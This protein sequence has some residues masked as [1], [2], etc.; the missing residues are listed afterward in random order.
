MR[1]SLSYSF[2][3]LVCLAFLGEIFALPTTNVL[4]ARGKSKGRSSL[5]DTSRKYRATAAQNSYFLSMDKNGKMVEHSARKGRVPE[6]G[7]D[8]GGSYTHL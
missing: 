7:H 2:V 4:E 6:K 3:F 5:K 1:W 8:A